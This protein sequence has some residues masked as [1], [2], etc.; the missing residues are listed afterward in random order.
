MT[1][2]TSKKKATKVAKKTTKKK[3]TKKKTKVAKKKAA[4]KAGSKKKTAVAAAD[5]PTLAFDDMDDASTASIQ[6]EAKADRA[7]VEGKPERRGA[8]S[9]K[10]ASV[11]AGTSFDDSG[12]IDDSFDVGFGGGILED[13][14]ETESVNVPPKART[15]KPASVKKAE[16]KSRKPAR[17]LSRSEPGSFFD[18]DDDD[19]VISEVIVEPEDDAADEPVFDDIDEDDTPEDF[20]T[21]DEE[22]DDDI[23]DDD[24]DDIDEDDDEAESELDATDDN[25]DFL[26]GLDVDDESD[27]P[28]SN[29]KKSRRSRGRGRGRRGRVVEEDES[30][31]KVASQRR[32]KLEDLASGKTASTSR[33]PTRSTP[34]SDSF[35]DDLMDDDSRR[36]SSRPTPK[37]FDDKDADSEDRD[38]NDKRDNRGGQRRG[39]GRSARSSKAE[40]ERAAPSRGES[41]TEPSEAEECEMLINMTD[42]EEC[43]IA[44]L[45]DGRLDELYI[46]RASS[47]SNVGNIYKGRVTNIEPSI[48]AAFVD[49]GLPNHGF[50]HI[51]DLHPQYFDADNSADTEQVGK[52]TPRKHRPPIQSCLKRGQEV[53]V[54]VIKEG[55]GTKGPTLSSYISIPGRFVV[56]MPGMEQLGVSRK[57]E[58]E[59]QRRKMRDLLG[60]LSLPNGMGFIVRTAG[61]DRNKRDLQRDLNYLSRLW[62]RVDER[63]KKV[64]APAELYKESDLVIR[65]IRD[66]YDSSLKKVIVDA[67]SVGNRVSEFLS[68]A[69]PRS[70]DVV[71]VYDGDEPLF[72]RFGIEKEI[73]QLYSKNVPLPCGGSLV[74]EQTEAMVA[75][76]VNSGKFRLHDDAE[77]TSFHV[78]CEAVDE[79][80][81]QL[82]LRDLGGLVVVDLIDMGLEKNRRAIERRMSEALKKHKERAKVLRISRF[83]LL[84]MTRQRQ[85]PSIMRNMYN[86]CPRCLGTGRLKAPESVA[87]DAMRRIHIAASQEGVARIDLRCSNSVANDLLNRKRRALV[88]MEKKRDL[89]VRIQGVDTFSIDTIEVT[90]IDRRGR[91]IPLSVATGDQARRQERGGRPRGGRGRR[92][93]ARRPRS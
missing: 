9:S 29:R 20:F 28:S 58:D 17:P 18:F 88:E 79:L 31:E 15:S 8:K 30:I 56:M 86:T 87:M 42:G 60:E 57:I 59:E 73:L 51:S 25:D 1:K 24:I 64:P 74:I 44:V 55:I 91:D 37:V 33:K 83:G 53:I 72:H 5:E 62:K 39:R 2:K 80:A 63:I 61:I 23:D 54:Q 81:R 35:A 67:E 47:S 6:Q 76:D 32:S 52:K 71:E 89:D 43:R 11:R 69:S 13:D 66:V 50:L 38:E 84:E 65:T 78:N 75:V 70:T 19:D 16:S 92:G 12:A 3:A 26:S 36:K 46:E 85:G 4:R 21:V 90:A 45:K 68:I 82:R 10:P 41:A 34:S 7:A 77:E 48:Q 93:G 27:T 40:P 22:D 14:G 49:F